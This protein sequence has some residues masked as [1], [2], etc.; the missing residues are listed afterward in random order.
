MLQMLNLEKT[1]FIPGAN[2][3]QTTNQTKNVI[4][5]LSGVYDDSQ[6][7]AAIQALAKED[8]GLQDYRA[9]QDPDSEDR[10]YRTVQF[11]QQ[12]DGFQTNPNI[13][14]GA[15]LAAEGD[16]GLGIIRSYVDFGKQKGS[17]YKKEK[18]GWNNSDNR[19]KYTEINDYSQLEQVVDTKRLN[20]TPTNIEEYDVVIASTTGIKVSFTAFLTSFSDSFTANWTDYNHVGQMDTFKVYKGATRQI[21]TAFKVVAGL[22]SEFRNTPSSA[23]AAIEKLNNLINAAIVGK[24]NGNYVE[25]PIVTLTIAGLVRDIKCAISSVKVDTDVAETGWTSGKPHVYTI[26]LDAAVLAHKQDKL[27]DQGVKYLG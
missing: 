12:I 26:S 24:Y 10:Q 15:A 25:G 21:S 11:I 13:V 8:Q 7:R 2:N 18:S 17:V 19:R 23:N 6:T 4:K 16:E 1:G 3:P 27:F 9:F 14:L 5:V 22:G 20:P